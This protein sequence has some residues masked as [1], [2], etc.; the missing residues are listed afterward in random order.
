MCEDVCMTVMYD[1]DNNVK[2][3]IF[4]CDVMSDL[5]SVSAVFGGHIYK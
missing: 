5:I 4:E 3:K 1:V 2:I